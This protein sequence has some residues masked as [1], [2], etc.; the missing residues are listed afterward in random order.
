M[1]AWLCS[2]WVWLLSRWRCL[3]LWNPDDRPQKTRRGVLGDRGGGRDG[4][5]LRRESWASLLVRQSLR[6][7]GPSFAVL[8]PDWVD[9]SSP[10]DAARAWRSLVCS[11]RAS[12]KGSRRAAND[13]GEEWWHNS[14]L[15]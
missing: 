4:D 8:L 2:R 7:C 6:R 10:L 15:G 13:P 9:H 1:S 11:R 5:G 3:L 14:A 12:P